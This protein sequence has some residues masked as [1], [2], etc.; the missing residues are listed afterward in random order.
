M[1]QFVFNLFDSIIQ[2]FKK[3]KVNNIDK[4]DFFED[5]IIFESNI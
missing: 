1:C 3:N 4:D 5:L 2:Y